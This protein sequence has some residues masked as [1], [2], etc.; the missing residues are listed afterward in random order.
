MAALPAWLAAF[1]ERCQDFCICCCWGKGAIYV[2][3]LQGCIPSKVFHQ[4]A[5]IQ[6][7]ESLRN[8]RRGETSRSPIFLGGFVNSMKKIKC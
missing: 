4:T 6:P 5:V 1:K 3:L 8:F 2:G 7:N